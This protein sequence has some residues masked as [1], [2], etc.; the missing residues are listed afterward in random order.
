LGKATPVVS[1]PATSIG[2][3]HLSEDDLKRGL[4]LWLNANGW[5]VSVK[6]GMAHG[7]D[8]EASRLGKRWVIETKGCG[9]RSAM[10]ANY[11]LAVLGETLQRMNDP[12]ARYSVAFPDM[13][14]FRKLW[15]QL[16]P[17]AKAR[18]KISALFVSASGRVCWESR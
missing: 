9:S 4:E 6:W 15:N 8:I 17:L 13:A 7:I 5:R 11:F 12:T 14:Q 1:S 3:N 10:R 16:P 2:S 18:S